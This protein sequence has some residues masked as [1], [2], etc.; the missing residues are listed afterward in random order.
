MKNLNVKMP[1]V[2][3]RVTEFIPEIIEF[4]KKIAENGFAYE[5]GGSVYFDT[6]AFSAKHAYAKLE[7]W[8]VGTILTF[9]SLSYKQRKLCIDSRRRR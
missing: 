2:L 5:S 3:T 8:S 9:F 7:P 6:L 1:D 4:V